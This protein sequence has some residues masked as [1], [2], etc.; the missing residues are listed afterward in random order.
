MLAPQR[1]AGTTGVGGAPG[2]VRV[3]AFYAGSE[4]SDLAVFAPLDPRV[5]TKLEV[6]FFFYL[7]EHPAGRVLFDTGTHPS[8]ATC[9]EQRLGAWAKGI[10]CNPH[11]APLELLAA[12][13]VGPHDI[14]YVAMSHL[15]Y[16]HAGGL[17][18]FPDATVLVQCRELEVAHWP[19]VYQ[20]QFYT[21]VDFEHTTSWL[22]L[23]GDYD[24]FGDGRVRL[25]TTPGHTE[26]HQ[27]LLVILD[28]G[29]VILAGDAAYTP[30]TF[31]QSI[32]PAI[33]ADPAA[34]VRSWGRIRALRRQY[35]AE[36]LF[37]HDTEYRE[38]TRLAP[39]RWYG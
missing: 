13:G 30:W 32:V 20:R 33:V 34:M 9:P 5:G 15:H 28:D 16:D 1:R 11:Q 26:G 6:P 35:D 7:V 10:D 37:T 31:E 38:T 8:V 25:F 24:V 3:G 39:E 14:D 18:F 2:S 23:E 27:S 19:P 17:E 12:V 29:A 36:V 4:E 22:E 21:T